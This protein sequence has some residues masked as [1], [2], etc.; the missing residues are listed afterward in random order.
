MSVINQPFGGVCEANRVR[1]RENNLN[2]L[3]R[4][5]RKRRKKVAEK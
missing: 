4:E 1:K 2:H 5:N 3:G